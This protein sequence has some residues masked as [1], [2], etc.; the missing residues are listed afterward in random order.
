MATPDHN[1]ILKRIAISS[2]ARLIKSIMVVIFDQRVS[3]SYLWENQ[4]QGVTVIG[5]GS[6]PCDP[7]T[8]S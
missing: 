5:D 2:E 1:I 6:V 3:G 4:H 7:I 8:P